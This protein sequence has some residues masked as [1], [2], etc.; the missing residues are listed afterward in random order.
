MR[1]GLRSAAVAALLTL[2]LALGGCASTGKGQAAAAPA[3]A[4]SAPAGRAEYR[5]E[6][7]A[8]DALRPLLQNYLDLARFQNAPVAD[9]IT[10]AELDRLIA[11]A[12]AQVRSLLETEGYFNP[13]VKV[14]RVTAPAGNT[15]VEYVGAIANRLTG[16]SIVADPNTPLLRVEVEPG[17]R[18]A[19]S[20]FLLD[21]VGALNEAA[22]TSSAAANRQIGTLRQQWALQPGE[23]FRQA[24]W[25]S[26]KAAT[27]AQLRAEGY[28]SA[29]WGITAA[30]IDAP[31]LT[32]ELTLVIDSGP[33][34]RLGPIR[35]E[36]L[37]RYDEDSVRKL[38]TFDPGTPYDDKLLLDFQER[39]QK[40]GLFEGAFVE[41]DPNP[42][43]A[44]AA[45]VLVRV[46]ELPL[47]TATIGAGYSANTGPRVTFEH[48]HRDVFGTRWVAKNKFELGPDQQLWQGDLTSHPLDGQYRNLIG[49]TAERLKSTDEER[50]SR[51]LR[52]GRTQDTP[53]IE[54]LY[55]AEFVKDRVITPSTASDSNSDALSGN[56]HWVYRV[57]DSVLLPTQGYTV[58][59]QAAAGYA[60]S[61][62]AD[63]G[64][65]GR[66]YT[67]FTGYWPLGKSWY[68]T[69]RVELGEVFAKLSVGVPDTLLFRA[70]G[71]D[72]VRGYAYRA[73]GPTIN[74]IV[75]SGRVLF[76]GSAEVARPISASRPAFWWALFADVGDAETQWAELKPAWG[77]GVGLRW[78]SPV[79]P[80]KLD[81]AYGEQVK[82]FRVHLSVGIAF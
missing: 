68:G 2:A 11:A 66:A 63:N 43:T 72:S 57:V 49:G 28:P 1:F 19:V 50:I 36:G 35:I 53:R 22:L 10:S 45:P 38:S 51:S 75:T 59:A 42:E 24:S 73:L 8:P 52:I 79:G 13:T 62:T 18:V 54:R 48:T 47:Q 39:L 32:A 6:V 71:D 56:Y 16:S 21:V 74:G 70:G 12:P 46:K 76:T 44:A 34:F 65:F 17:P 33:L 60:H 37:E 41:I 80:L 26:A 3:A 25:N 20:K 7:L 40:V 81:L 14:G 27:L 4:A 5:L 58:S 29:T 9:G 23:P 64:P 15:A 30:K 82:A 77:Y 78:R 31:S 55:Y 61:T 67:R 69:A